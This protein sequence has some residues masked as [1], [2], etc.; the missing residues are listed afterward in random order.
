MS[1]SVC[2]PPGAGSVGN[3]GFIRTAGNTETEP[4]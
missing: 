1:G 3:C 4:Q 2:L